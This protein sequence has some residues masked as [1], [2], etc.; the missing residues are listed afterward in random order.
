[1]PGSV[2][3]IRTY[4]TTQQPYGQICS[5]WSPGFVHPCYNCLHPRCPSLCS[6]WRPCCPS[7][8]AT[9]RQPGILS[10]WSHGVEQ[11]ASRH[12]NCSVFNYF[13]ESTQDPFVYSILL[14]NLISSVVCCTLWTCYGALQI[15][16]LLLCRR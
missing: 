13:Q 10:R 9:S 1:M 6:P 2:I 8:Q 11:L 12:W 16:V 14:C 15:V 3:I 4:Y 7:Y 5:T